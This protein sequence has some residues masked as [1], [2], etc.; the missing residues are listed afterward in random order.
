M[1]NLVPIG[2]AGT[3]TRWLLAF[4]HRSTSRFINAIPGRYKHV[5]AMG[6]VEELNTWLFFDVRLGHTNLYAARGDHAL[7]LMAHYSQDADLL[8]IPAR[9]RATPA[10]RCGFWCVPSVKHLV[11][12]RG[13]ALRPDALWR[14]CV[15]QGATIIGY[16][17][18]DTSSAGRARVSAARSRPNAGA[19]TAAG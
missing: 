16:E 12:I 15:A 7:R 9:H 17:N 19:A 8:G 6:Y 5:M 14:D 1:I 3:P 4:S 2:G 10:L 18:V 11:G 13:G